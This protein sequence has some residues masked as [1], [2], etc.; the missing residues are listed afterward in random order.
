MALIDGDRHGLV[1]FEARSVSCFV[2]Y[3]FLFRP[4]T[5]CAGTLF[6]GG[7]YLGPLLAGLR[8]P[9]GYRLFSARYLLSALSALQRTFFKLLHDFLNFLLRFLPIS[10]HVISLFIRISLIPGT[11][12][13]YKHADDKEHEKSREDDPYMP[14][15][16][17]R[18]GTKQSCNGRSDEKNKSTRKG[19]FELTRSAET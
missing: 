6:L 18:P 5:W 2:G 19:L 14:A 9:D 10:G 13:T 17:R 11:F 7:R 12:Y 8:E 4:M 15:C 16:V 1:N 3:G